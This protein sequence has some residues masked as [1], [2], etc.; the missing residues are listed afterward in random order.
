[1]DEKIKKELETLEMEH[2]V[3]IIRQDLHGDA[4]QSARLVRAA[5]EKNWKEVEKLLEDGAD[6]RICREATPDGNMV[7]ALYYALASKQHELAWK[8]YNAGDRLDDLRL[9]EYYEPV[10]AEMMAFL[11]GQMHYGRNYFYDESK[12]LSEC[13][14]CA[15]FEQIGK[16]METASQDEL[17]K[18]IEP[19]FENYIHYKAPIY[20]DILEDLIGRG[21]KLS[22][23]EKEKLFAIVELCRR[24]PEAMRPPKEDLEKVIGLIKQA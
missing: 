23:Q 15:A 6:P 2:Y 22:D 10:P 4:L 12:P 16:L 8:L 24:W 13:C 11:T 21:A 9:D 3:R 14:R 19:I 17:N 18:S 5:Q 20:I 7:S 1:M